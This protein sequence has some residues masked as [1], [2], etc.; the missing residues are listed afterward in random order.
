MNWIKVFFT[1]GLGLLI[2]LGV[3]LLVEKF[4]GIASE[5]ADSIPSVIVPIAYVLLTQENMTRF[6]QA[7]SIF[8][9]SI[10]I[11]IWS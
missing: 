6:D 2:A 10:G 5:V 11:S 8:A 9:S 4:G 3:M 1:G 7:D